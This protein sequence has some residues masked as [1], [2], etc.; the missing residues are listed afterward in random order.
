MAFNKKNTE[1]L[2]ALCKRCCC[3]CHSFCG[4]HIEIHHIVPKS[5]DGKDDIENAIALC[6][7]CH[8]EVH[9]N[10][11]YPR[12]RKYSYGELR[13][14]KSFWLKNAQNLN[15]NQ[16]ERIKNEILSF[17]DSLGIREIYNTVMGKSA[18]LEDFIKI[19]D[20]EAKR[21]KIHKESSV[22]II[23]DPDYYLNLG[24]IELEYGNH[25]EARRY[26][27]M[28]L[29]LGMN[30]YSL[31]YNLY[32]VE[33]ALNNY[34]AALKY[35]QIA[36]SLNSKL[37]F[38][39][40]RYI[41]IEILGASGNSLIF[42]GY[43]NLNQVTV[44]IKIFKGRFTEDYNNLMEI[45]QQIKL[46]KALNHE[47][48][49]KFFE[50]G[51]F[52]DRKYVVFNFIEG[53]SLD[54]VIKQKVL[55]K[56]EKGLI[57]IKLCETVLYLH[58][59]SILH[60]DIKPSNII[61]RQ[62]DKLPILSDLGSMQRFS[63]NIYCDIRFT[64]AYAAPELIYP[65][66]KTVSHTLMARARMHI[67]YFNPHLDIYSLGVTIA[68]IL[69]NEHPRIRNEYKIIRKEYG[70]ELEIVIIDMTSP[71]SS[72]RQNMSLITNKIKR[73]FANLNIFD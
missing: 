9:L 21:R 43:D 31:Y 3:I 7:K 8:A 72:E 62:E 64:W 19:L 12:G 67:D 47:C 34:G 39:P 60:L 54:N 32:K 29:N 73:I 59:N 46:L 57:I 22:N 49:V 27:V 20:N 58:K 24:I 10:G 26:L 68:E 2:L 1:I 23:N 45:Q 55:T 5:E 53:Q 25:I 11:K 37:A 16:F 52:S 50:D 66:K 56:E 13:K 4:F 28:A 71:V 44:L 69:T 17:L 35:Y 15:I 42:K 41:I 61:I 38:V 36:I 6:Y 18:Q 51:F 63:P 14:H 65:D 30:K 70:K 48:I 33:T 40:D